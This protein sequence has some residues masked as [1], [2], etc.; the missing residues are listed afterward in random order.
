MNCCKSRRFWERTKGGKGQVALF[1][2]DAGSGKS[3][4]RLSS[5]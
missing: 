4:V 1:W 2:D 3:W 5:L